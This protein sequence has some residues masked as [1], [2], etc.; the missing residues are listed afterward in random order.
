[1]VNHGNLSRLLASLVLG[2]LREDAAAGVEARR[3]GRGGDERLSAESVKLIYVTFRSFVPSFEMTIKKR[4][5][6]FKAP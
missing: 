4:C 5:V 2:Q 6:L 1:M 3:L